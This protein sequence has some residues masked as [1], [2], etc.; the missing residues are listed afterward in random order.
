MT[1]THIEITGDTASVVDRDGNVLGQY[2]SVIDAVAAQTL[3]G[4]EGNSGAFDMTGMPEGTP[5]PSNDGPHRGPDFHD[6]RTPSVTFGGAAGH[7]TTPGY[8]QSSSALN[9]TDLPPSAPLTHP[10]WKWP[11]DVNP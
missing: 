1:D 11:R 6:D 3:H 7:I 5:I 9:P 8:G 2:N 10:V 4:G